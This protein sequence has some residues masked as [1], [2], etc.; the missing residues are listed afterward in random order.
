MRIYNQSLFERNVAPEG[1]GSAMHLS[2]GTIEYT[3]PA[4]PGRWLNIRQGLTFQLKQGAEDLD[5]PYACSAG[6]VSGMSPG[7]Q[8]GPGCSRPCP[9]GKFCEPA[10]MQPQPCRRGFYCP[11][12]TPIPIACPSGRYSHA[13]D[14]A[15]EAGCEICPRGAWC[16][17]G[18]STPEPCAPGR[19]GATPGQSTREC[20][21]PCI[22][23]H[24]CFEGSTTN[25]SGICRKCRQTRVPLLYCCRTDC[26]SY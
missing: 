3:L 1:N 11:R 25:I 22:P 12:A 6:T 2:S 21:G 8:S 20:T 9:A 13:T 14:L 23:G 17:L 15:S 18:A 19:F 5:F 10:T 16:A 4:P 26:R 7:E 24:F